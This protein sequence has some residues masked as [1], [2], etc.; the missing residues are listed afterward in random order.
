MSSF[1]APEGFSPPDGTE[2]G[3]TFEAMAEFRLDVGGRLTLVSLEGCECEDSE[4][5]PS[6]KDKGFIN[7]LEIKFGASGLDQ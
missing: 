6:G 2:E 5:E 3:G 1:P 4:D 7:R